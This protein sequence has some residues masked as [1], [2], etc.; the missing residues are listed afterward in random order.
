MRH[1][2][3]AGNKRSGTSHLVR[4]L[5]LHPQV[6]VSHESDIVWAL[7]QFTH[8]QPFQSHPWDSDR[9]LAHT[10]ESCGDLF[11]RERSPR[12]NLLAIQ[13]RLMEAGTPFLPPQAKDELRWIGD[14]KPFQHTD[15]RLVAFI[16]EHF[17]DAHF[18]HIV[19][20]PFAVAI[21][22]NRFNESRGG[23]FWLDLTLEEKV[24]RWTF[25]EQ[26]VL[27]L[28]RELPDRVHSLRY[29]DLCEHTGEELS[30]VFAFLQLPADPSMLNQAA[31]K[32]RPAAQDVPSIRCSTETAR[33]ADSYG[34]DLT[35]G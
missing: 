9:G 26:H 7:Y 24:E 32:T 8:N 20:H 5:N 10:L 13:R 1:L 27:S 25:H 19:R 23:D 33:I 18:L 21:S 28:R 22:S 31:R 30:R 15:P 14:K 16:L 6:F 17:P 12:E 2:F 29:E 11:R 3:I 34:Y 4:L 35:T